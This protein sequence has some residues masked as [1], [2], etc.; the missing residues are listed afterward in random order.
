MVLI[1]LPFGW[2]DPL[3]FGFIAK[4]G[5]QE[6][7]LTMQILSLISCFSF[8]VG[9]PKPVSKTQCRICGKQYSRQSGLWLHMK[10]HSGIKHKCTHCGYT[11]PRRDSLILHLK[12]QHKVDPWEC[13]ICGRTFNTSLKYQIHKKICDQS[14][15]L[16]K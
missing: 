4:K 16:Q 14:D 12:S 1:V 11:T 7:M 15:C 9:S 2:Y 6:G 5:I 3:I 8:I 10:S 13:T